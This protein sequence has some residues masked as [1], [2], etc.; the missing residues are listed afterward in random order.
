M[1]SRYTCQ[2]ISPH[3]GNENPPFHQ[4]FC[5]GPAVKLIAAWR[6]SNC[7]MATKQLLCRHAATNFTCQMAKHDTLPSLT[8][9]D[10]T[11][12]YYY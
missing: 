7:C 6:Q 11:G 5:P 8:T 9:P 10:G 4:T 2:H 12:D 3:K 1:I